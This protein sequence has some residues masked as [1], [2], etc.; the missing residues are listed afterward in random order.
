MKKTFVTAPLAAIAVIG[1]AACTNPYD[2]GQRAAG[3]ALLGAGTGA[4]LG[5]AFG[6]GSG[7]VTG[8]LAGGAIGA[9]AGVATTPPPPPRG[10][11]DAPPPP[12]RPASM[13]WDPGRWQ[14]D[15]RGYV[16]IEGQYIE[17]PYRG[18]TR[19]PGR[20]EEHRGQWFWVEGRWRR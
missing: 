12:A 7:A 8:A 17:R 4:L 20:W 14:W 16:W 5:S 2:P 15:G 19:V 3:G 11:Y 10:D 1:L 9:L 13:V 18:A 6:G